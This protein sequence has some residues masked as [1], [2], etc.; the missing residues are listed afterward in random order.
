MQLFHDLWLLI[1][2]YPLAKRIVRELN[3]LEHAGCVKFQIGFQKL[4][5]ALVREKG[6]ANDKI[7]GSI[8]YLSL[9]IAAWRHSK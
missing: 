8:V 7:T 3:D 1:K 5:T 2:A 4:H 6:Y 9:A